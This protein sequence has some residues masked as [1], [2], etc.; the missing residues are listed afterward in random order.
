M[1]CNQS[2]QN[3]DLSHLTSLHICSPARVWLGSSSPFH[4]HQLEQLDVEDSLPRSPTGLANLYSEVQNSPGQNYCSRGNLMAKALFLA[5]SST[6]L[7]SQISYSH[8]APLGAAS[9]RSQ[10]DK[11]KW[12]WPQS[13]CMKDSSLT[14]PSQDSW[15]PCQAPPIGPPRY[16]PSY[17]LLP[18]PSPPSVPTPVFSG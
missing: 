1:L 5:P 15:I 6:F 3:L 17:Q 14:L 13:M 2:L 8:R 16:L 9:S 11:W 7:T 12:G 10:V 4:E 18:H